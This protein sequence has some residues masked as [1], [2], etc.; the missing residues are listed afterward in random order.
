MSF[1]SDLRFAGRTLRARP[2][3]TAI[4]VASLAL[5]IGANT[6]IFSVVESALLRDLPYNHPD[7]LLFVLD[8]QPNFEGASLSPGEYL[9]YQRQSQTLSGLAA[10]AFQS[11][12]LTRRGD[13]QKLRAG[14]DTQLF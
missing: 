10:Y 5:G 4:A 13:P 8:N 11:L 12:T 9:D 1:L 2:V 6:A 14:C 7:S 3:F